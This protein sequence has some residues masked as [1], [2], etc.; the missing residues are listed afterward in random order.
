MV[1]YGFFGGIILKYLNGLQ[2]VL[3]FLKKM[4]I[5]TTKL[6]KTTGSFNQFTFPH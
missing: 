4:F 6:L 3:P 5:Y 1:L 2:V